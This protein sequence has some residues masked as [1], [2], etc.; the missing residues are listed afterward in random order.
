MLFHMILKTEYISFVKFN[1][2]IGIIQKKS[3]YHH[4]RIVKWLDKVSRDKL[5]TS[6]RNTLGSHLALFLIKDMAKKESISFINNKKTQ[7]M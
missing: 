3:E 6:T 4:L 5:S 2:I 7:M 1:L